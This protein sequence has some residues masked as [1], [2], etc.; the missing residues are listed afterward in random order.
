MVGKHNQTIKYFSH[1]D[2][3]ETFKQTLYYI[4]Y[5]F[6]TMEEIIKKYHI[7]VLIAVVL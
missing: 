5:N 4:M 2:Q 6:E 3:Q 7:L 1:K